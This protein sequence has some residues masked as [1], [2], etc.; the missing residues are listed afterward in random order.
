MAMKIPDVAVKV[1]VIGPWFIASACDE[2]AW[3]LQFGPLRLDVIW[4]IART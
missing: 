3:I 1:Q 4:P 2:W